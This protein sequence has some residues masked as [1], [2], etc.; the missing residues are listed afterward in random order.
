MG[1]QGAGGGRSPSR[2]MVSDGL[3]QGGLSD[4]VREVMMETSRTLAREMSAQAIKRGRATGDGKQRSPPPH[5][6]GHPL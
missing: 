1:S 4:K 2:W 3:T 6:A 5:L